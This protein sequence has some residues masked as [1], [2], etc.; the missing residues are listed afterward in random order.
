MKTT[1]K[2]LLDSIM[3][4]DGNMLQGGLN[5]LASQPLPPK[6]SYRLGRL[7]NEARS[8]AREFNLFK[9]GLFEKYGEFIKDNDGNDTE[10]M[11]IRAEHTE[12]CT[13]EL[14]DYLSQEKEIWYEPINLSDLE[15][16]RL[17]GNDMIVLEPFIVD[18]TPAVQEED[19]PKVRATM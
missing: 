6:V 5:R 18:D 13:K 11:K 1:I 16:C 12:V 9:K 3:T 15:G 10:E 19:K 14:E 17:T 2:V 4:A 7:A 8:E